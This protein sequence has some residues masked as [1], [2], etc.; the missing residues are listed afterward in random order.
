MEILSHENFR[1]IIDFHTALLFNYVKL[2]HNFD[3][4][5]FKQVK[6]TYF[7]LKHYKKWKRRTTIVQILKQKNEL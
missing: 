1:K 4:K 3:F 2:T 6:V 7:Q 5:L